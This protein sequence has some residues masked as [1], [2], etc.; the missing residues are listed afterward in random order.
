M[1]LEVEGWVESQDSF[2]PLNP[3][4]DTEVGD[5]H[6]HI[7]PSTVPRQD[8]LLVGRDVEVFV[9]FSQDPVIDLPAIIQRAWVG[10]FWSL[11]VI[12]REDGDF[13]LLAPF[14]GVELMAPRREPNEST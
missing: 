1:H 4:L 13:L 3:K 9:R 11:P 12:H 7:S 8:D 10:G 5:A 14:P 6:D 2:G